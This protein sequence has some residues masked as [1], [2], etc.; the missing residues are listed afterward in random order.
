MPRKPVALREIPVTYRDGTTKMARATGNNA[1]WNCR[2]GDA[3][4]LI[5]TLF[6]PNRSTECPSCGVVCILGVGAASV[7][8]I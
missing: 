1:A 4:P 8:E 6:P 7:S 3:L 2:C 5:A